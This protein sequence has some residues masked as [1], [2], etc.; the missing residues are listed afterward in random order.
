[1]ADGTLA[2]TAINLADDINDR[3]KEE[4]KIDRSFVSLC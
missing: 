4:N 2:E 1:M 3:F